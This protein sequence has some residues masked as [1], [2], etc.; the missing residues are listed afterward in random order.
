MNNFRNFALWVIIALLVVALFNLM[1]GPQ[2]TEAAET[3]DYSQFVQNVDAG[4]VEEVQIR[5]KNITGRLRD[6]SEKFQTIAPDDPSLID[7][8]YSKGVSIAVLPEEDRV[9]SLLGILVSWF[10][11]LLLIAVWIFF[12]RQMHRAA[13][14]RWALASRKRVC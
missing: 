9:P 10:P 8:L 12:M 13:A 2:P 3:I 11:M 5:G 1:N 14:K 7:R 6:T 4:N